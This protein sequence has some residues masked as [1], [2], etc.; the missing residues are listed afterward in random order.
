MARLPKSC[1][2]HDH[3]IHS[4][5]TYDY[6][7]ILVDFAATYITTLAAEKVVTIAY[8]RLEKQTVEMLL[9]LI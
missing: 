4:Q 2:C 7:C 9:C 8:W 1:T 6:D 5:G 3:R